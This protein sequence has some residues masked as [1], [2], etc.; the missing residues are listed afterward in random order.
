MITNSPSDAARLDRSNPGTICAA[1]QQCPAQT[2]PVMER[3]CTCDK[4]LSGAGGRRGT[5]SVSTL[6]DFYDL[7]LSLAV[8]APRPPFPCCHSHVHW[9][10]APGSGP[11][12]WSATESSSHGTF[13]LDLMVASL[14]S[15]KSL[16]RSPLPSFSDR[17]WKGGGTGRYP[18]S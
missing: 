3:G 17:N 14:I 11:A 2:K 1:R 6:T 5:R 15:P 18:R 10:S 13:G 16:S 8:L 9:P 12:A 4:V 7:H